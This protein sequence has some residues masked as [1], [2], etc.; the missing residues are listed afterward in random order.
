VEGDARGFR[1]ALVAGELVNPGAGD[2]DA[3]AVL[4]HEGWGVIQ[5]PAA[6]YP[7]DVA[8]PLLEQA[9]EQAEEFARHGYVLALVGRHD[10]L[11]AVLDRYGLGAPP[12]ILPE[13]AGELRA[14]LRTL[15]T[16]ERTRQ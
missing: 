15:D 8:A 6:D 7:D 5:L 4:E 16:S 10:G 12:A 11:D 3:L 13:S 1:V 14:F 2:V 9:A